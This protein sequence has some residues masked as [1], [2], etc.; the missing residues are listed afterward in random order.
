MANFVDKV[1]AKNAV[2]V[3]S[4]TYCPYCVKA[5]KVLSKYEINSIEIVELETKLKNANEKKDEFKE[6]Y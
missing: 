4:K 3:F 6:K 2:A 5:K 1:I